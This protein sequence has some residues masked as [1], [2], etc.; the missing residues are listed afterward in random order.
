MA[1]GM[2][3]WWADPRLSIR[4][5]PAPLQR[6]HLGG[7][8]PLRREPLLLH[9]HSLL[10]WTAAV[11]GARAVPGGSPVVA[12]AGGDGDLRAGALPCLP[13]RLA[14]QPRS[15]E[16]R[17]PSARRRSAPTC[18]GERSARAPPS[19]AGPGAVRAVDAGGGAA[20]CFTGYVVAFE[21]A[22]QRE[23]GL[24]GGL[25]LLPFVAPA[26]A[27]LAVRGALE[28]GTRGSRVLLGSLPRDGGV[29]GG[30]C[31]GC[32]HAAARRLALARPRDDHLR[33]A[34]R[35]ALASSRRSPCWPGRWDA[36]SNPRRGAVRRGRAP[37][38]SRDRG[39]RGG[40]SW[41]RAP[42]GGAGDRGDLVS[43]ASSAPACSA[44]RP[45]WRCSSSAPGS[46]RARR[47]AGGAG[48]ATEHTATAALAR[49]FAHLV[50][51]PMTS[52]LVA[53]APA[54]RRLRSPST[55]CAGAPRRAR[56]RRARRRARHGRPR[57]SFR[58]S[59]GAWRRRPLARPRP[60][61]RL[62]VLLLRVDARTVDLIAPPEPQRLLLSQGGAT[63]GAAGT[64]SR[65]PP[66]RLIQVP[67]MK[68][69]VLEVGAEG[70]RRVRYELDRDLD[71]PSC[72]WISQRARG[73]L[74][75]GPP[76]P[77][78]LRQAV[79]PVTRSGRGSARARLRGGNRRRH[80][81]RAFSLRRNLRFLFVPAAEHLRPLDGLRALSV[82]WV[83]VFHA[84]SWYILGKAVPVDLHGAGL[85][86]AWMLPCGAATSASTCSSVLSGFLIAGLLIEERAH[87][88]ACASACS[89]CGA[90]SASGP[91]SGWP[92]SPT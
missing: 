34:P 82:L 75:R 67:G 52:F 56:H 3:T 63:C 80:L 51:G 28:Y 83:V 59:T 1:R 6:A 45:W 15:A 89:T 8:P 18:A 49:G 33:D 32:G 50:H 4:F 77:A 47:R 35:W 27:Y 66:A 64:L 14:R 72:L 85:L 37:E 25:W 84:T 55:R 92:C 42:G 30:G 73:R 48:W 54:S 86:A 40:C 24:D 58:G 29:P 26:A 41:G 62:H 79:R 61:G 78:G 74:P 53:S 69:R 36:S 11:L 71:A 68:V 19:R 60:D 7:A 12:G 16:C 57:S 9:L 70:P 38:A 10:W 39:P 23:E 46:R 65:W 88:G 31:R 76:T 5:F 13:P 2:L 90:C 43:R 22:G 44:W 81:R 91:R 20:F 21:I 87:R 17:W